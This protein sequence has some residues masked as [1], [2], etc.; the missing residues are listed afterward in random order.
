ML[1]DHGR[2]WWLSLRSGLKQAKRSRGFG[3]STPAAFR[4][5]NSGWLSLNR[6]NCRC[7]IVTCSMRFRKE[8]LASALAP[9]AP[10]DLPVV[11][12]YPQRP[13]YV[14]KIGLA[15][16]LGRAGQGGRNQWEETDVGS[17]FERFGR[18]DPNRSFEKSSAEGGKVKGFKLHLVAFVRL[19]DFP[20]NRTTAARSVGR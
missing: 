7:C 12:P 11:R 15:G 14:A 8:L 5:R 20:T 1:T 3:G 18:G 9:Q 4:E 19:S 6:P 2:C 17:R 16:T 13:A 10:N